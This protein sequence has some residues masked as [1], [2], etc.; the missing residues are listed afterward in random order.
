M[1]SKTKEGVS[2]GEVP[3][4]ELKFSKLGNQSENAEDAKV[5][6]EVLLW[7]L[8]AGAKSFSVRGSGG[9]GAGGK[10]MRKLFHSAAPV[11]RVLLQLRGQLKSKEL[12]SVGWTKR[13]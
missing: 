10:V 1:S 12:G 3:A 8:C 9:R 5:E 11:L 13:R 6:G 7:S 4:S 2:A